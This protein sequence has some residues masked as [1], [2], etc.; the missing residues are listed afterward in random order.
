MLARSSTRDLWRV[1]NIWFLRLISLVDDDATYHTCLPTQQ[2]RNEIAVLK[3]V[4]KGHQNVVTLHDYFEVRERSSF[5]IYLCL[6]IS[7]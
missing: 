3:R 6:L 2:V 7:V 1:A 4:S 5:S